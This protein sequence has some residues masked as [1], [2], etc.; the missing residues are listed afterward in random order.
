MAKQKT[1]RKTYANNTYQHERPTMKIYIGRFNQD[2]IE[3]NRDKDVIDSEMRRTGLK[4]VNTEIIKRK[5]KIIGMDIYLSDIHDADV[6]L[7]CPI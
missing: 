2:D 4:Y 7:K 1:T 3:N 6:N 5:G